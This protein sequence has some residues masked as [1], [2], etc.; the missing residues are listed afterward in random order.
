MKDCLNNGTDE[1]YHK[2]LALQDY[3]GAEICL[4]YGTFV[5]LFLYILISKVFNWMKIKW[6]T[7]NDKDP[8][9]MLIRS[10]EDFLAHDNFI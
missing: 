10:N 7:R 5:A 4:F 9:E 3:L 8:F 1:L 6:F 2:H